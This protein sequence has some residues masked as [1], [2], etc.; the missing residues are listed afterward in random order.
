EVGEASEVDK[1]DEVKETETVEESGETEKVEEAE[2]TAKSDEDAWM[3]DEILSLTEDDFQSYIDENT[4]VLVEFY[5]PW[6]PHC[7]TVRML[8]CKISN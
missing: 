8:I 7:K 2:E 4:F 3:N 5:A 6:C 1:A